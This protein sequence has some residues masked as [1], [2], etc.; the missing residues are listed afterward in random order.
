MKG[1][2]ALVTGSSR[3]LG[4][5]IALSFANEGADVVVNYAVN[6]RV[7]KETYEKIKTKSRSA[8]LEKANVSSKVEVDRMVNRVLQRFGKIDILVNNAG[9]L[10]RDSLHSI[11]E[12]EW[13]RVFDINLRG[14]LNCIRAVS[15][16]MMEKRYGKIINISSVGAMV[17]KGLGGGI[18][19]S[20]SKAALIALTKKTAIELGPYGINVNVIAPGT[21]RTDMQYENRTKQEAE[22]FMK[23]RALET[24]LR[25][26]GE[27]EDVANATLFL[28]SDES[29]FIAGQVLMVDGGRMDF[30]SKP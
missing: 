8:M 14:P 29:S 7:A 6:E 16:S 9:I 4:R 2:V 27:P 18:A 28:A 22:S 25:R 3:G 1:R 12:D 26:I 13:A 21:I 20:A 23:E 5:A 30:F 11:K 15:P 19:Y 10:I 24:V 17:V